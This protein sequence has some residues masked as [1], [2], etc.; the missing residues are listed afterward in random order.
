MTCNDLEYTGT[1]TGDAVV[2]DG[3]G[4][5]GVGDGVGGR[6][7]GD[8]VGGGVV[9]A[10]LQVSGEVIQFTLRSLFGE[11]EPLLPIENGGLS[12]ESRSTIVETLV[13]PSIELSSCMSKATAPATSE[14][15]KER[16]EMKV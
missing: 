6:G 15:Y 13:V 11:P 14:I 7:V 5:R 16:G 2:G 9:G 12:G 1:A 4:G 3:V 8:G 10:A